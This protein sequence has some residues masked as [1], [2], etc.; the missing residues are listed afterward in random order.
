MNSFARYMTILAVS[1][2]IFMGA[3]E[4]TVV[5]NAMP[6]IVSDLK[7]LDRYG[8]VLFVYLLASTV[9]IPLCGKLSIIYS[10]KKIYMLG[11]VVFLLG[12]LLSGFAHSMTQLILFRTIQGIGAGALQALSFAIGADSFPSSSDRARI[13]SILGTVWAV[14]GLVGPYLGGQIVVHASWQWIFFLN[15][16]IGLFALVAVVLY[17]KQESFPPSRAKLHVLP[18]F[19][20]SGGI[21]CLLLAAE[22]HKPCLTLPLSML[23]WGLF[24]WVERRNA[25]TTLPYRLFL[26]PLMRASIFLAAL[27][28]ALLMSTLSYLPLFAQMVLGYR[29]SEAG[30]I[31][32]PILLGWPLANSGAGWLV[33]RM[34]YRTP[35]F[36]GSVLLAL[37]AGALAWLIGKGATVSLPGLYGTLFVL[38][39]G[40]GM[41][42]TAASIV[43]QNQAPASHRSIAL[44]SMT[45]A[46]SIGGAVSVGGLGVVLTLVLRQHLS[47][48]WIDK[49]LDPL[50]QAQLSRA[51][52]IPLVRT[53]A[54]AS[55][56]VFVGIA[57]LAMTALAV[58][59]W[60]PKRKEAQ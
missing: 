13:H 18:A 59:V 47:A 31:L 48:D 39:V 19:L 56:W 3:L 36:V 11:L 21:V 33:N 4:M 27:M 23:F 14:A 35:V 30:K 8:W 50:Q 25:E 46:R 60:F 17:Y 44:S 34:G 43:V 45:F 52:L 26:S 1:L 9:M 37:A 22:S 15:L 54:M 6:P 28:G 10:S 53:I 38:G 57:V 24:G 29:A 12:S 20:L 16:P 58:G 41:V 51:Q 40:I 5:V 55:H 7:G 49:I 42:N 2:C 32:T